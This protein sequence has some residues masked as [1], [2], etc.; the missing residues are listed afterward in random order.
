[1][2][3]FLYPAFYAPEEAMAQGFPGCSCHRRH[4]VQIV[5]CQIRPG[6]TAAAKHACRAQLSVPNRLTDREL[7]TGPWP[8]GFKPCAGRLAGNRRIPCGFF[9]TVLAAHHIHPCQVAPQRHLTPCAVGQGMCL[10]LSFRASAASRGISLWSLPLAHSHGETPRL[11]ALARGD[12][13][14]G[15]R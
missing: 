12:S 10:A 15:T 1:M 4:S 7:R 3:H 5:C 14:K 2:P 8:G 11:A 13:M 6:Q 9:G